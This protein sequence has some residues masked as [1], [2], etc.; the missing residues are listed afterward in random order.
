[1]KRAVFEG[2]KQKV[3]GMNSEQLMRPNFIV[4]S[5]LPKV[6]GVSPQDANFKQ[7]FEG[8]LLEEGGDKVKPK[9]DIKKLNEER[10]AIF[11]KKE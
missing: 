8:Y 3:K 1:M 2:V 4:S 6:N 5:D 7:A 11:E 9:Y 10:L